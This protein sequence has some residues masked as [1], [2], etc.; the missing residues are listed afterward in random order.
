[1][2]REVVHS[3]MGPA[4]NLIHR[5]ESLL[6]V[7]KATSTETDRNR[8]NQSRRELQDAWVSQTGKASD[9]NRSPSS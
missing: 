8:K 5:Y 7:T 6:L 1:M 9:T 2:W 3:E 4:D